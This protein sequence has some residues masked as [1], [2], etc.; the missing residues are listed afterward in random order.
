[1]TSGDVGDTIATAS[2][3]DLPGNSQVTVTS[4]LGDNNYFIND[5]DMFKFDAKAYDVVSFELAR[6]SPPGLRYAYLRL[7][8]ASGNELAHDEASGLGTMPRIAQYKITADGTYY[9]G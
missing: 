1:M 2:P 3:V 6:V 7:F 4:I 9:V 8:D 5:I